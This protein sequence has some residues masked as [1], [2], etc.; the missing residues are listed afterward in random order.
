[1]LEYLIRGASVLDGSGKEAEVKNVGI[2]NGKLRLNVPDDAQA[3]EVIDA[4]G[5]TL[6]PGF[7]DV[8]GHS[9]M[10]CFADPVR[11]SKT[12]QGITTE[13]AG[14]CGLGPAPISLATL[15]YYEGYYK[16]LGAPVYP[17]VKDFTT[18][19]NYLKRME[20]NACGI[21]LAFF[22]PHGTVRLAAMGMSPAKATAKDLANMKAI[23]R[24]GMQAGALGVSSGLMYAPGS[25]ADEEELTEVVKAAGEYGGIYTS[26]IRDQG[27]GLIESVT[28]T[29]RTARNGGA[30]ANI[31][32]HKASGHKNWGRVKESTRLI[33]EADIPVTHDVYPYVASSTTITS[34]LPP[35]FMGLG[36]A[37][38]LEKLATPEGPKELYRAI[39]EGDENFE[40]PIKNN[41]VGSILVLNAGKTHE[42][43]GKTIG[44]YAKAQGMEDFDAYIKLLCE[45]ELAITYAGFE[46]CEEDVC[47]LLA[48]KTC[49]YG[50][51]GLYVKGMPVTH[52][53]AIGTFPR[54][55]GRYVREQKLITLPEAVR[56]MTSLAAETYGLKNKGLI[57]ENYDADLVLF[58]AETVIDHA[59]FINSTAPNEGIH[60]VFVGGKKTTAG[61]NGKV[62]RVR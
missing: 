15:P 61:M 36:G 30:K 12:G 29:I 41:G 48:D 33:H 10:F 18:F 60:T 23:V 57:A 11:E 4:K 43:E 55:L 5:L 31:S 9:D 37:K 24:E 27:A 25:F 6:T 42:V 56:K 22:I 20:A 7:I 35:S 40:N 17:D 54:I 39:F 49:M 3:K 51:D 58:D 44:D 2:E 45:N 47:L 38:I 13:L 62:I 14:Q 59:D 46:M 16:N 8:H 21:N 28:E 19:D 32:H 53:R 52:P 1:M 34:T 50:T 26:H